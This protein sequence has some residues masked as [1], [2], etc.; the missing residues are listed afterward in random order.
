MVLENCQEVNVFFLQ[1][2]V[3]AANCGLPAAICREKHHNMFEE[4]G[5]MFLR[6]TSQL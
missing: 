4:V 2:V 1:H 6:D 5:P 3:M